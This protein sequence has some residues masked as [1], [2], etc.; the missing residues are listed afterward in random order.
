MLVPSHAYM[1]LTVDVPSALAAADFEANMP[2]S[3]FSGLNTRTGGTP[4]V[5]C[6]CSFIFCNVQ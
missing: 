1:M 6:S 3:R 4:L 2:T 5:F